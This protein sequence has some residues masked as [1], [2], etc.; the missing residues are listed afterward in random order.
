MTGGQDQPSALGARGELAQDVE[1]R[2][3]DPATLPFT[4]ALQEDLNQR[5]PSSLWN[6]RPMMEVVSCAPFSL[7]AVGQPAKLPATLAADDSAPTGS[8]PV[9]LTRELYPTP[10][11]L[12]ALK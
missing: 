10:I 1:V 2:G 12:D 5:R 9:S 3:D 7:D 11:R 6:G 4:D 8:D